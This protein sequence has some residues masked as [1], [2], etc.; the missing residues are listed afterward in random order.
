MIIEIGAFK[1][2]LRHVAMWEWGI[3]FDFYNKERRQPYI[4]FYFPGGAKAQRFLELSDEQITYLKD[5][6][7][8]WENA[9]NTAVELKKYK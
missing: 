8:K 4:Q 6:L 5:Q 9:V 7:E 1:I 2:D 3:E